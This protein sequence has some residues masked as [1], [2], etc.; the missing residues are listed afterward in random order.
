MCISK[1]KRSALAFL[2]AIALVQSKRVRLAT[3]VTTSKV[4][5]TGFTRTDETASSTIIKVTPS[6]MRATNEAANEKQQD[7]TENEDLESC[8]GK[9]FMYCDL[10]RNN[11]GSV[12]CGFNSKLPTYEKVYRYFWL[13]AG[14]WI[15]IYMIAMGIVEAVQWAEIEEYGN[16]G[17]DLLNSDAGFN[18]SAN[19]FRR[20][21]ECRT[22]FT[23]QQ[24]SNNSVYDTAF[25]DENTT[26]IS[27]NCDEF[28][29]VATSINGIPFNDWLAYQKTA[30]CRGV[31]SGSSNRNYSTWSTYNR[32]DVR[33]PCVRILSFQGS[34]VEKCVPNWGKALFYGGGLWFFMAFELVRFFFFKPNTDGA[35]CQICFPNS[36]FCKPSPFWTLRENVWCPSWNKDAKGDGDGEKKKPVCDNCFGNMFRCILRRAPYLICGVKHMIFI[37]YMAIFA[38]LA[39]F[40]LV[41]DTGFP[42]ACEKAGVGYDVNAIKKC[43]EPVV[44]RVSGADGA[45]EQLGSIESFDNIRTG[46][47]IFT[48]LAFGSVGSG[49]LSA[50]FSF[51]TIAYGLGCYGKLGKVDPSS[52]GDDEDAQKPVQAIATQPVPAAEA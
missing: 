50:F 4:T 36:K 29:E 41:F 17:F 13:V 1:V 51:N 32:P 40:I 49:C 25:Y 8:N 10:R 22:N 48:L 14:I 43:Y 2:A 42:N 18:C 27:D 26:A 34:N 44:E 47:A 31:R 15:A 5:P 45:L 9:N 30:S 19:N 23:K 20:I 35:G 16:K 7:S 39:V 37:T 24:F 38:V 28:V 3:N 11:S 52:V 21:Y 6:G 12:K 46:F 33:D